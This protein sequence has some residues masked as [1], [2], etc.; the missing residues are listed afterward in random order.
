MIIASVV[1][2]GVFIGIKADAS[3]I[4]NHNRASS[5]SESCEIMIKSATRIFCK[6][7]NTRS[8]H[9]GIPC[10]AVINKYRGFVRCPHLNF[11]D[12]GTAFLQ[13]DGESAAHTRARCRAI[14]R[15]AVVCAARIHI[16]DKVINIENQIARHTAPRDARGFAEKS[17]HVHASGKLIIAGIASRARKSPRC[18]ITRQRTRRNRQ[19]RPRNLQFFIITIRGEGES[20]HIALPAPNNPHIVRQCRQSRITDGESAI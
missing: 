8:V 5:D 6:T 11:S 2:D 12:I 3:R 9:G 1:D 17:C 15:D 20:C 13:I 7:Q 19:S 16:G 10:R 14:Q 18:K 4:G